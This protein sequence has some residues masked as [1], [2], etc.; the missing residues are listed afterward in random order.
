VN[1]SKFECLVT[2]EKEEVLIRGIKTKN[3]CYIWVSQ[4]ESLTYGPTVMLPTKLKHQAIPK[5]IYPLHLDKAYIKKSV[6]DNWY[7]E[8][9]NRVS[10]P[11]AIHSGDTSARI[12][13]AKHFEKSEGKLDFCLNKKLEKVKYT[14]C[15]CLFIH[16]C[17]PILGF[18]L[19]R[20]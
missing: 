19:K 4:G 7:C 13:D 2:N 3:N 5:E 8:N 14:R 16:Y 20:A 11:C 12:F 9:N 17:T 1:F 15:V 6:S 18:C 10:W